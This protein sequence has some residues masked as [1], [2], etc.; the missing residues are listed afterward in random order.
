M[1]KPNNLYERFDSVLSDNQYKLKN[2]M[3]I[4]DFMSN[5][6]LQAGYPV[7]NIMKNETLNTYFVTQVCGMC[8]K[9][10][11]FLFLKLLVK[12]LI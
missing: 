9:F 7:L 6:T 10:V 11:L 5:W 12:I 2:G 3:K 8:I 1:V 4:Y